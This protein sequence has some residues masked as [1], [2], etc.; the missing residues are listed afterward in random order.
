MIIGVCSR[1]V[2]NVVP[3]YKFSISMNFNE[4]NKKKENI[5]IYVYIICREYVFT[6]ELCTVRPNAIVHLCVP[7][8]QKAFIKALY[9]YEQYFNK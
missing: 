9:L 1:T 4:K 2:C 6:V 3:S 8:F 7:A 5:S